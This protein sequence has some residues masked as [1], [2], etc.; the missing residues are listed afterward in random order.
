MLGSLLLIPAYS[1]T[2]QDAGPGLIARGDMAVSGFS[3]TALSTQSLP[4]GVNPTDRTFIDR[5]GLSVRI[6]DVST[7]GGPSTGQLVNAPAK[8]GVA[9]KDIGQVFALAFDEG[10]S[11]AGKP[12]ALYAAATSAYGIHI[13]GAQLDMDGKPVRLKRG[14]PDAQFM[15]G[16]FGGLPGGSPGTIWK[17]DGATGTATLFADT[18]FTGVPNSGPGI[19]DIAFDP[20]SRMLYA[21]DLD[22]GLIH[23]FAIDLNGANL[24]QFDHGVTGRPALGLPVVPDDGR[25]MDLMSPS[26]DVSDLATWGFAQPERRVHALA[27][28]NRRL[29]YTVAAEIFSVGLNPDGSFGSDVRLEIMV[30]SEQPLPITDILF[31]HQGRMIVAQRGAQKGSYDYGQFVEIGTP[32]VLRYAADQAGRWSPEPQE[33]AIGFPAGHRMSAGGVSLQYAFGPDGRLN[34]AA[35]HATVAATGDALRH[36]L[37]LAAQLVSGGAAAVHGVQLSAA[38]LAALVNTPPLQSAFI[39]FDGRTADADERGHIGDVE[40]LAPCDGPIALAPGAA[41]P[42]APLPQTPIV[43]PDVAPP[44]VT[45]PPVVMPPPIVGMPPPGGGG[46]G[47]APAVDPNAPN[48]AIR[49]TQNCRLAGADKAECD[50][51]ITVTNTGATPFE[52]GG[53]SISDVFSV[54]P[55]TLDISGLGGI[56]KTASGF[57]ITTK[58]D[59][60]SNSIPPN[61]KQGPISFKATFNVPAGGLTVENCVSLAFTPA[62]TPVPASFTPVETLPSQADLPASATNGLDRAVAITGAPQCVTRGNVR[63]CSWT[64]TIS[65]PGTV[66]SEA[67]FTF[68]TSKPASRIG[69]PGGLAVKRQNDT[70]AVFAGGPLPPK[71][72]K[73]FT[74]KGTFPNEL[75]PVTATVSVGT[76]FVAD[77]NAAN[78]QANANAGTA[79]PHNVPSASTASPDGNPGDNTSCVK[80][81]SNKPNDQGTPTNGPTVPPPAGGPGQPPPGGPQQPPPAQAQLKIEKS[82]TVTKCTAVGG[83]CLFEITVTNVGATSFTGPIDIDD[84]VKADGAIFGATTIS[85][86]ATPKLPWTCTKTGQAFACSH[87]STTLAPGASIKLNVGFTLGAGTAAKN[88]ENCATLKQGGA[89]SCDKILLLQDSKPLL[90]ATKQ[91]VSGNCTPD[92]EFV[93]LVTNIGSAPFVGPFSI[94]D[95]VTSQS[96]STSNIVLSDPGGSGF[97]CKSVG[98]SSFLLCDHPEFTLPPGGVVGIRL[99]LTIN[100]VGFRGENCAHMFPLENSD[101]EQAGRCVPISVVPVEKGPGIPLPLPAPNIKVEKQAPNAAV[102]GGEGTCDLKRGC[103]FTIV[104]SNAGSADYKGKIRILD[105]VSGGIPS[106]MSKGPGSPGAWQCTSVTEAGISHTIACE[107]PDVTL[108]K[109]AELRLEVLVVPGASWK[110]NDIL[111]NCATFSYQFGNDKGAIKGDDRSCATVKLDPFAL[112]LTK[113]GSQSCEPGG[114]CSFELTIFNPG[115]IDHNAPITITDS[116]GNVGSMPIVSIVPPLKCAQQ[117]TQIPFTC[118]T[119]DVSLPLGAEMKHIMTVRLLQQ[120]PAS[121]A[122]RNCAE[123]SSPPSGMAGPG[124]SGDTAR[125]ARATGPSSVGGDQASACHE[126]A[127]APAKMTPPPAQSSTCT[128]GMVLNPDGRCACPPGMSWAGRQCAVATAPATCPSGT[129]GIHPNCVVAASSPG[130]QVPPP[131]CPP[132]TSG[133]F[134]DCRAECPSGTRYENGACRPIVQRECPPGTRYAE[135]A[136]RPV[137]TRKCPTGTSGNWPNCRAECP[138]GTRLV[139]N[140]CQALACPPGTVGTPPNCRSCPP[141]TR[142]DGRSCVAAA[143]PLGMTGVPPTC[144]QPGTRYVDGRCERP[145]QSQTCPRGTTGTPPNCQC[146]AGRQWNGTRCIPLAGSRSRSRSRRPARAAWSARLP[147]APARLGRECW[148]GTA[149]VYLW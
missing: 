125:R 63:D 66:A 134:P 89:Q 72:V 30:R 33:Y 29:Y 126:V 53:G 18:A 114:L 38:E 149:G 138:Q 105:E 82:A 112:K 127:V 128:G 135:G 16:L 5:E 54:A 107:H 3:G 19:G 116:M 86:G 139:G 143:C 46:V 26:F 57:R 64:V 52:F 133:R 147:T 49:K 23:Q 75:G 24:A 22:T 1:Q 70:T 67:S 94:T 131:R 118:T 99:K 130:T 80:W 95:Q 28:N 42:V 61:G 39:D 109:G 73:S 21:S 25:R 84:T 106:N 12:A 40:A 20:Q 101:N 121:G 55:A 60:S 110:K 124:S 36:N 4:P 6:F 45:S 122:F 62:G 88:I 2:A 48:L 41:A 58:D 102:P 148:G 13:T 103:R 142:F 14:A 59:P 145:Q 31:D 27:V 137:E 50:Y 119:P 76:P 68:V 98:S 132:G 79:A 96:G 141:N 10:N 100:R 17:I 136:C 74:I 56:E 115:P 7:L 69:G 65:N 83:G 113:V 85:A 11:A 8:H 78:N 108:A 87:P 120:G 90:R 111:T 71:A 47:G 91:L 93:I 32:R 97:K 144:C 34:P 81:D 77:V 44:I 123:I 104:V 92:C 51:T 140:V 35:C 146:P 9:A 15:E 129:T 37:A 43:D 117:P